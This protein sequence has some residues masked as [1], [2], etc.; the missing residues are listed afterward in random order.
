MGESTAENPKNTEEDRET[1]GTEAM[2]DQ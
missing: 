2:T 1:A